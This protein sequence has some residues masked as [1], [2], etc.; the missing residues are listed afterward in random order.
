MVE[1]CNRVV[2]Y[3]IVTTP[4]AGEKVSARSG[5]AFG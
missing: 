5:S 1:L 4:E 2:V 3:G